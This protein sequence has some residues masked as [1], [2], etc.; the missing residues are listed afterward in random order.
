MRGKAILTRMSLLGFGSHGGRNNTPKNRNPMMNM[1]SRRGGGGRREGEEDDD[2]EMRIVK[3]FEEDVG[4]W[5]EAASHGDGTEVKVS[6]KVGPSSKLLGWR[7]GD[8]T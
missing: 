1:D 3:S 2:T 6:S 5:S 8:N 4:S 7:A